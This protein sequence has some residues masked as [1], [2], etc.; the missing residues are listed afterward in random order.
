MTYLILSPTQICR[1]I[2]LAG[3][4]LVIH[5]LVLFILSSIAVLAR[6]ESHFWS[7]L[8]SLCTLQAASV[9]VST[10]KVLWMSLKSTLTVCAID[11]TILKELMVFYINFLSA[12]FAK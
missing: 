6:L 4:S 7:V 5:A 8:F 2:F 1:A 12:A 11:D 3:Y 9:A 10:E